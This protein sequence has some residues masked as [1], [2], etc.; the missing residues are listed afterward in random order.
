M[1]KPSPVVVCCFCVVCSTTLLT[2]VSCVGTSL[3]VSTT[4]VFSYDWVVTGDSVLSTTGDGV[5]STDVSV[6]VTFSY[7][8]VVVATPS[9]VVVSTSTGL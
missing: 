8:V 3:V 4:V 9:G 2:V 1:F 6:D 5:V 7:I